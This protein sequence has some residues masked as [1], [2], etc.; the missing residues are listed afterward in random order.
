M[1]NL[2]SAPKSE[3]EKVIIGKTYQESS[4][5]QKI[6]WFH[7]CLIGLYITFF[8]ASIVGTILGTDCVDRGTVY[9]GCW[10]LGVEFARLF[11]LA[12]YSL[13]PIMI[14]LPIMFCLNHFVGI[15]IY[16]VRRKLKD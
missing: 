8:L 10:F 13:V 16:Y 1:T 7:R 12:A 14:V 9:A 6:K 2:Y 15:A 4:L 3:L 11:N 5:Y